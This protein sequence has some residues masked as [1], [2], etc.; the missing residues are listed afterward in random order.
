MGAEIQIPDIIREIIS[1]NATINYFKELVKQTENIVRSF[2]ND[3][4][5][6]DKEIIHELTQETIATLLES[7]QKNEFWKEKLMKSDANDKVIVSYVSN[8]I[9]SCYR[10][11][12]NKGL[13]A[14]EYPNLKNLVIKALERLLD[15]NKI[16]RKNQY[17]SVSNSKNN[18]VYDGYVEIRK[19]FIL[20]QNSEDTL[21]KING[22]SVYEAVYDILKNLENYY[23]TVSD[24]VEILLS[25]SDVNK[26]SIVIIDEKDEDDNSFSLSETNLESNEKLDL[27]YIDLDKFVEVSNKR[28]TYYLQNDTKSKFYKI[29]FYLYYKAGFTLQ[30]VSDYIL[31]R[32]N[33]KLSLQT[34][35]NYLS[36]ILLILD[37]KNL[38]ESDDIQLYQ[39]IEKFMDHIES[40]FNLSDI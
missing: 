22:Q 37:L 5:V 1:N 19:F 11:I 14:S 17:Y 9:K 31:L 3:R 21:G 13:I 10:K 8:V 30:E 32:F 15:E 27:D 16:I 39:A 23:L 26:F 2:L 28:I 6:F 24:I 12:S 33:K 7:F 25:N 20:R 35:K 38:F 40:E 34:I 29:C 36:D 18:K 4:R